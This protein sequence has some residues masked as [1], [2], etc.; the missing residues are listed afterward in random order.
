MKP[1]RTIFTRRST[2]A[3][4][5]SSAV[6]GEDK[7]LDLLRAAMSAPSHE[8]AKPWQFIIVKQAKTI[9]NLAI[10]LKESPS[11]HDATMAIVVCA[12]SLEQELAGHWA[13]DCSAATE[14][15]ILAAHAL[16]LGSK[17]CRIFPSK[18]KMRVIGDLFK[19]PLH[20][21]PFSAVFLGE[22]AKARQKRASSINTDQ[23]HYETW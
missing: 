8:K 10:L 21:T 13:I 11:L 2:T 12:D 1:L 23:I 3:F 16:D 19:T 5:T 9:R 4:S 18:R 14:N 6:P 15:I 20:I 7:T 17:W 22:P